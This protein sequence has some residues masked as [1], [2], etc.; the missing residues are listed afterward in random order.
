MLNILLIEDDHI[1]QFVHTAMLTK[2]NCSVDSASSGHDA[3]NILS[4][5]PTYYNIIFS[6]IGLPDIDGNEL[7][8]NLRKLIP[9]T[10]IIVLTAAFF[11]AEQKQQYKELG[12]TEIFNK[13]ISKEDFQT[14]LEKYR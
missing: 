3:L 1:T 2:L 5:K 11:S 8:I 9:N 12:T 6:D 7:L 13:P 4:N 14:L 10:P